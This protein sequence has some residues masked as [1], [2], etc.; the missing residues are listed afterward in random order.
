MIFSRHSGM[1]D[2]ICTIPVALEL[3]KRHPGATFIYNCHQDFAAVPRLAGIADLVTSLEPI[4]LIGHW[5]RFLLGGFYHFAHGD[6]QSGQVAREPMVAEFLRQFHL[7]VTDEHPRLAAGTG[8]ARK[9]QVAPG[10]EKPRFRFARAG[11][12]RAKLAGQG[13]AA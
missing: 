10:P 13:M 8:S 12:P 11:P 5:Y 1:G 3:M 2:I 9:S 4:G 7:P 6:D